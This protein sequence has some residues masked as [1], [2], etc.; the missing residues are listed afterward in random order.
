MKKCIKQIVAC[1]LVATL[2]VVNTNIEAYAEEKN[3]VLKEVVYVDGSA[4]EVTIDIE[5]GV[6][7]SKAVDSSDESSL[8]IY[9]DAENEIT[10]YDEAEGD[11]VNY[12]IEIEDLTEEDVDVTIIGENNEIVERYDEYNDLIEDSYDGQAAVAVITI[13]TAET[14]IAAVLQVCACIAVAGVIYY[15]AKAA[16]KEIEKTKE[17]KSYYYKAYI[18]EKNVF[19]NLN[20]ISY[21]AAVSRIKSGLNVYTYTAAQAKNI[22]IATGLGCRPS[23]ISCLEG[24]IRFYHY[25]P[26]IKNGAHSF[27][28]LPV[29]Y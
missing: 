25:H 29:V 1:I 8:T 23:E 22:V 19:I 21:N 26:G 10:V 15:G 18:F 24:K 4:I 20:N 12:K 14:L 13:I 7:S 3:N 2:F 9:R 11:F 16:V 28:G 17:R 5:N 27:Y 6:I